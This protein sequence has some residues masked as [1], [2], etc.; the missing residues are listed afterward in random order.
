MN[1]KEYISLANKNDAETCR[2]SNSHEF[3]NFVLVWVKSRRPEIYRDLR[4]S[5][6]EIEGDVYALREAESRGFKISF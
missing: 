6:E 1:I 2:D 5:F 3:T 4:A